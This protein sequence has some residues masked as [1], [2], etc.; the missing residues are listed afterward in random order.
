M[1]LG[2]SRPQMQFDATHGRLHAA[3]PLRRP[4]CGADAVIKFIFH[5]SRAF[6]PKYWSSFPLNLWQSVLKSPASATFWINVMVEDKFYWH[7]INCFWDLFMSPLQDWDALTFFLTISFN[8]WRRN[9]HKENG[10]SLYYLFFPKSL[11][12]PWAH[13][14]AL[15]CDRG[16]RKRTAHDKKLPMSY[17]WRLTVLYAGEKKRRSNSP[18]RLIKRAKGARKLTTCW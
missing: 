15:E 11:E 16:R 2:K 9:F 12:T 1:R 18:G 5:S 4:V 6:I 17:F 13:V 8:L 10:S 14:R 7:L 3:P